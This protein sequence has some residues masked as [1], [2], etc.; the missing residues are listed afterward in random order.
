MLSSEEGVGFKVGLAQSGRCLH[1]SRLRVT[2]LLLGLQAP[3]P[4]RLSAR[5]LARVLRLAS[6]LTPPSRQNLPATHLIGGEP[7]VSSA[8]FANSLAAAASRMV[9][10]KDVEGSGRFWKE[11][12]WWD[13][14]LSRRVTGLLI[15]A[16]ERALQMTLCRQQRMS[17]VARTFQ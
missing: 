5:V 4:L 13:W 7:P 15:K 1:F 17:S 16:S 8:G 11:Q 10:P 9:L 2:A 12:S 3:C 14:G 6:H